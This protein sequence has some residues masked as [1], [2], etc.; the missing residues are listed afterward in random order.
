MSMFRDALAQV[1]H[2]NTLIYVKNSE[3]AEI[4]YV[5]VCLYMNTNYNMVEKRHSG[6]RALKNGHVGNTYQF[7]GLLNM[8]VV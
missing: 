5:C 1:H 4:F 2:L 3:S 6:I 7:G 8:G